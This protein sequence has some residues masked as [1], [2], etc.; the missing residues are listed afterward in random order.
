MSETLYHERGRRLFNRRQL[1]NR[2]AQLI[3]APTFADPK[4]WYQF[5]RWFKPDEALT[6][7]Q[8]AGLF[9]EWS[10]LLLP[11]SETTNHF[12]ALGA[13]GSGKSALLKKW[14]ASVFPKVLTQ[15]DH[16]GV[17]LDP[18]NELLP[19][20]EGIGIKP[21]LLDPYDERSVGWSAAEDI[22]SLAE[23]HQFAAIIVPD[24]AAGQDTFWVNATRLVLA[25]VID[26]FVEL[27]PGRWTLRDVLLTMRS[28]ERIEALLS[29]RPE[30]AF[31]WKNVRGDAKTQANLMASF[32]THT[33]HF[34]V[35]AALFERCKE[36]I[37]IRRWAKE[38]GGILLMPSHRRYTRTLAPFHRIILT[39]IADETLSLPDN[40]QRRTFIVLDE[41]RSYGRI[42][43]LYALANEGRSKGVS[44]AIGSQSIEGLQKVYGKEESLE[45]VGQLRSKVFLRNDSEFSAKWV[46]EHIGQVQYFVENV[47]HTSGSSGGKW[48]S[49]SSTSHSRRVQ[50]LIF[51]S[52][53]MSLPTPKPG[54]DFVL[55]NDL[56]S[57]GGCFTSTYGFDELVKSISVPATKV[58]AFQERPTDHQ[59]LLDWTDKDLK[60]LK[61]PDPVSVPTA[62]Q[63]FGA[64][65]NQA[66]NPNR[67]S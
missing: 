31:L 2:H 61:L 62:E 41:L 50:P 58:P 48:S 28:D 10:G 4:R 67:K 21:T 8:P 65:L 63:V 59:R 23:A 14:M 55:I 19:W 35:V 49:S 9:F 1:L 47:S 43:C 38:G 29:R 46:Q 15:P 32:A 22:Q 25:A 20:F 54:G 64:L 3:G 17:V 13:T 11:W 12:F 24:S 18:K 39:L 37:S 7:R 56:P 33:Q 34:E 16:R 53:V 40:T 52:E 26:S 44:L 42:D 5:L 66:E 57:V 51:A 30:S 27:R 60:R 36:K 45:I 6:M